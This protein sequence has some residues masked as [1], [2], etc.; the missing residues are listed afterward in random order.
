MSYLG[1][2]RIKIYWAVGTKVAEIA[3]KMLHKHFFSIR[4]TLKLVV[5]DDVP[6]D[7]RN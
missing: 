1:Y 3:G 6:N 7:M 4:T 2:P 5:D